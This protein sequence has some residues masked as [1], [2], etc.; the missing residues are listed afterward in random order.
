LPPPGWY[1]PRLD[2]VKPSQPIITFSKIDRFKEERS[3]KFH[4]NS[5]TETDLNSK[6]D[7]EMLSKLFEA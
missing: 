5:I 7:I 1:Q 4:H 2:F 3:S 6:Y